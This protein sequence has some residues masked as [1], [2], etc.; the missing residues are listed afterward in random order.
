MADYI[1]N[2]EAGQIAEGLIREH[3]PHLTGIKIAQ[4]LKLMPIPKSGKKP[5]QA[6]VGKKITLA[7]TSKVSSKMAALAADDFKFVIEYGSLY[8]DRM[9]D[10]QKKALVD[11]EL[12][13][14]GNDA[15]GVYLKNHDIE[16]FSFMIERHGCW[17][18]DVTA[19]VQTVL[20]KFNEP[21][22]EEPVPDGEQQWAG[23]TC[24]SVASGNQN[25]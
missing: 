20:S 4:L 24:D 21:A 17:K 3:H 16:D 15:D 6:R 5:K 9:D 19:F 8:W 11:H 1:P 18:S 12:G 2:D 14:C 25:E 10:G 13:H 7:K 22:A 23:A